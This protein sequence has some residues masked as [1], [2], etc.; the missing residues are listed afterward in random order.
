[1]ERR[2]YRNILESFSAQAISA[3]SLPIGREVIQP[4]QGLTK[5]RRVFDRDF[6]LQTRFRQIRNEI[7]PRIGGSAREISR[8]LLLEGITRRGSADQAVTLDDVQFVSERSAV[9]SITES[10]P[11]FWPMASTTSELP[12]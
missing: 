9:K 3:Q 8:V 10:G 7:F 5:Y 12:S 2:G 11:T 6:N 1:M 4:D